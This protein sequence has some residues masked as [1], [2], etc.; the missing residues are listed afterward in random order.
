[1][2]RTVKCTRNNAAKRVKIR[3]FSNQM[4]RPVLASPLILHERN[5]GTISGSKDQ[6]L[7]IDPR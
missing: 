6:M 3:R 7:D 4:T 1:M 2:I 5:F